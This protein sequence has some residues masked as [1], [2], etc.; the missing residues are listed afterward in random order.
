MNQKNQRHIRHLAIAFGAIVIA[1]C[2][3]KILTLPPKEPSYEGKLL[4]AWLDDIDGIVF[5][6]TI[7]KGIRIETSDAP[8]K[9][10]EKIGS[11]AVPWLQYELSTKPPLA[12]RFLDRLPEKLREEW[13]YRLASKPVRPTLWER[14]RRAAIGVLILGEKAKPLV[15]LLAELLKKGDDCNLYLLALGRMQQ[16]GVTVLAQVVTNESSQ[17]SALAALEYTEANTTPAVPALLCVL[18]NGGGYPS[19]QNA[20]INAKAS[21]QTIPILWKAQV[22]TNWVVRNSARDTL[23]ILNN[24]PRNTNHDSYL[25]RVDRYGNWGTM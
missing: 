14:H 21:G 10:I 9:A 1:V 5:R 2:L 3:I 18:T 15:P 11:E 24:E 6:V 20:F 8:V 17:F 4:H 12:V 7:A 23:R 16:E 19:I 22:D 13:M 25:I